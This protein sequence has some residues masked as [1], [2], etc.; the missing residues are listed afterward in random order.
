MLKNKI[1]WIPVLIMISTLLLA[2]SGEA[3]SAA[4]KINIQGRITPRPPDG[5]V[6]TFNI[7]S[8][9]STT[10]T[11]DWKVVTDFPS[12]V[13]LYVNFLKI[14][15]D[16]LFSANLGNQSSNRIK[17]E[18]L[19]DAI[20]MEIL[21]GSSSL[22]SQRLTCAPFAIIAQEAESLGGEVSVYSNQT[23]GI[24]TTTTPSHKLWVN[25][26]TGNGL[27]VDGAKNIIVGKLGI[28]TET[29]D[30]T[31]NISAEGIAT[32]LVARSSIGSTA[33]GLIGLGTKWGVKGG[34]APGTITVV[35][36]VGLFGAGISRGVEGYSSAGYTGYFSGGN[37]VYLGNKS[38]V[39]PLETGSHGALSI[40]SSTRA[41]LFDD[42]QI[43][44]VGS[45]MYINQLSNRGVAIA[46]GGGTVELGSSI[47]VYN[48]KI[49]IGTLT[50]KY[51]LDINN[52]V[53]A[54]DV[55]AINMDIANMKALKLACENT[56]TTV[57]LLNNSTYSGADVIYAETKGGG[58]AG[59][60]RSNSNL[61]AAGH[62]T[63]D[64]RNL[65]TD[66]GTG[67]YFYGKTRG[68]YASSAK[69]GVDDDYT[70]T[71]KTKLFNKSTNSEGDTNFV[72]GFSGK[73]ILLLSGMVGRA[74]GTVGE[75]WY[76]ITSNRPGTFNGGR[77]Y[78]MP[79]NDTIYVDLDSYFDGDQLK[80]FVVY[81]D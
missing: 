62:S 10:W 54:P 73:T 79:S 64:V 9:T 70:P 55:Y 67:G 17:P 8:S 48:G 16:G 11:E 40:K 52:T 13:P 38:L 34:M 77:I 43:E 71:I 29:T 50:P 5:T 47:A 25:N 65:N 49:G 24:G 28:N 15:Q 58:Q 51:F 46:T 36:D 1:W 20:F 68:I 26:P 81:T 18:H 80:I 32:A 3:L 60:F 12:P 2:G 39:A 23:V 66:G 21:V 74:V 57:Y 37:G 31:V 7:K 19:K 45:K 61:T 6:I 22:G 30:G 75:V 4:G 14:T 33:A 27:R 59:I 72:A 42:N 35:S 41:L 78:Y 76:N 69:I 56:G 44:S 63:I 53:T